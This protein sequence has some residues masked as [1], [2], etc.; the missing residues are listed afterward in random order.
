[1]Y[2]KLFAGVAG[3]DFLLVEVGKVDGVFSISEYLFWVSD[4]NER[5]LRADAVWLSERPVVVGY[6]TTNGVVADVPEGAIV[7]DTT[8]YNDPVFAFEEEIYEPYYMQ[9]A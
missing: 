8:V 5:L 3:R 7:I 9:V 6:A 1:M 2:K 4:E